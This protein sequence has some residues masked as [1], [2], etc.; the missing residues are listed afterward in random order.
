L[1]DSSKQIARIE[2]LGD[3]A[4]D[5][6]VAMIGSTEGLQQPVFLEAKP[7]PGGSHDDMIHQFDPKDDAGFGLILSVPFESG[8]M[9]LPLPSCKKLRLSPRGVFATVKPTILR[10]LDETKEVL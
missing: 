9:R 6:R 5:A 3:K 10:S 7:C 8:T 2:W 4:V 1:W